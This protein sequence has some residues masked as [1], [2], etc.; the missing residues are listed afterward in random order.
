MGTTN[1]DLENYIKLLKIKNF[2]GVVM[3]DELEKL[4]PLT[5]ECFIINLEN[6]NQNG[7]H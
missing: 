6:S 5:N 3:K 1:K 4:N 7:S 2:R